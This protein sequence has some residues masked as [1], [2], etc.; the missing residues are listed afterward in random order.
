MA[1]SARPDPGRPWVVSSPV[2]RPPRRRA[3]M[4]A[5]DAGRRP[6]VARPVT[7]RRHR[8]ARGRDGRLSRPGRLVERQQRPADDVGRARPIERA[9]RPSPAPGSARRGSSPRNSGSQRSWIRR[10]SSQSPARAAAHSAAISPGI[11]FE[12]TE[13]TPSP[14]IART[15]SV[16]ASSPA[17]TAK[18]RGR[19]RQ[20]HGDLVEVPG[21][22]LDRDDP[23]MLGEP[24]E[25]VGVDVRA[26]PRRDV[27]DDDR[28]VALVGDRPV[29]RLE[30][31]R[32]GP[33]VVRRDDERGV[34]AE[35]GGPT[36]RG[37]GRR[38]VVRAGAGDDRDPGARDGRSATISTVTAISRSRS[39]VDR[40]GDSPV[41]PHGTSP[42]M[43]ARTCQRTSWR[44]AASS[45][46]PSG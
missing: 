4:P 44:N 10:A 31:P 42:S 5:D 3:V 26:G 19:S 40:V 34:G 39:P 32:V 7:A 33:V 23:R 12:A 45:S 15:G 30:H 21:G 25:R 1:R 24:Q 11:S 37:D 28:Q 18:S 6:R 38:G 41:V 13:T 36:G 43:P 16:Q 20:I 14:P 2:M 9:G 8:R 27:V 17:R 22:F 29:V 35:L 46:A